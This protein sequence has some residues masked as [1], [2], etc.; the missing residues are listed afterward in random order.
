[1]AKLQGEWRAKVLEVNWD[2]CSDDN[3][4]AYLNFWHTALISR[5][6]YDEPSR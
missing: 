4:D 3:D 2:K 5:S 1:M 6:T